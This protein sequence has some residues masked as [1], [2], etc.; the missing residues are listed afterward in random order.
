[1]N[2]S[3]VNGLICGAF[4]S[5]ALLAA[6]AIALAQDTGTGTS[7]STAPLPTCKDGTTATKAGKGGCK[8]HGGVAKTA[9]AGTS[10]GTTA[11]AAPAAAASKIGRAHV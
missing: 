9:A 4:L 3:K 5:A 2:V 11:A 10:T 6:P 1:M 8:G 7:A